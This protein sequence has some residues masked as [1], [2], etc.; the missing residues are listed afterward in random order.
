[1]KTT[2]GKDRSL[3]V[4]V[5]KNMESGGEKI[6]RNSLIITFGIILVMVLLITSFGVASAQTNVDIEITTSE[7]VNVRMET[8]GSENVSLWLNDV[9]V[10]ERFDNLESAIGYVDMKTNLNRKDLLEFKAELDSEIDGRK[11]AD[12]E[13]YAR[14]QHLKSWIE[15][16]VEKRKEGD[17]IVKEYVDDE[18]RETEGERGR[19]FLN[20]ETSIHDEFE[21]LEQRVRSIETE[22][23]FFICY[24]MLILVILM[25]ALVVELEVNH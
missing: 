9:L 24:G 8:V 22:M 12:G 1:M 11:D 13:L 23:D 4:L 16:E 10:E 18:I 25:G 17:E 14:T 3:K 7:N 2:E 15:E 5:V 6:R 20:L 19:M 21:K